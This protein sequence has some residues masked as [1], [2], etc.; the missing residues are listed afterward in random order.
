MSIFIRLMDLV[1]CWVWI[2]GMGASSPCDAGRRAGVGLGL[3]VRM[4]S[5]AGVSD[6]NLVGPRSRLEILSRVRLAVHT[7]RPA[8]ARVVVVVISV[9]NSGGLV[10][11]SRSRQTVTRQHTGE[12]QAS[13]VVMDDG[14]GREPSRHRQ[15]AGKSLTEATKC[16]RLI[17]AL[18]GVAT[19]CTPLVGPVHR[20]SARRTVT[21]PPSVT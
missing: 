8:T 10:R 7:R 9:R 2:V 21:M 16:Y 6:D 17:Q 1:G 4:R 19:A 12:E 3:Q 11:A 18:H 15:P 13:S 14:L 5:H 20:A